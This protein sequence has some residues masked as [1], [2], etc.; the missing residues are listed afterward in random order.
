MEYFFSDQGFWLRCFVFGYLLLS[1]IVAAL[2][3]D[4]ALKDIFHEDPESISK[5]VSLILLFIIYC[6]IGVPCKSIDFFKSMKNN[7]LG[8]INKY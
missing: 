8:P 2:L 6:F 3:V 7:I 5:L 4:K 1:W